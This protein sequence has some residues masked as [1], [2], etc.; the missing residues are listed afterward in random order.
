MFVVVAAV[1][2]R[3]LVCIIVAFASAAVTAVVGVEGFPAKDVPTGKQPTNGALG[4]TCGFI[5][6]Y[7]G[8]VASFPPSAVLHRSSPFG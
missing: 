6:T 7:L 5:Y 3:C 4:C 1:V 2:Q 8:L